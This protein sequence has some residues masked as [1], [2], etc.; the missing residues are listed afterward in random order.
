MQ[1]QEAGRT[2]KSDSL[3]PATKYAS[4]Y[5]FCLRASVV[6]CFI[7]D[8]TIFSVISRLPSFMHRMHILIRKCSLVTLCKSADIEDC[9]WVRVRDY[10]YLCN[11]PDWKTERQRS[12][13]C[14]EGAVQR[15]SDLARGDLK[16]SISFL[17]EV[18]LVKSRWSP[19]LVLHN[20]SCVFSST[21]N[22]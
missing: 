22:S 16:N 9:S 1:L 6:T 4:S 2:L 11:A 18:D 5:L 8:T 19:N 13:I 20:A 7:I 3:I 15:Y 12:E 21:G 14:K 10:G 17:E